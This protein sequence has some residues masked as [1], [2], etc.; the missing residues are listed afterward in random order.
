MKERE[1]EYKTESKRLIQFLTKL[2]L[3]FK[4]NKNLSELEINI[5]NPHFKIND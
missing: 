3:H 1:I 5:T 2:G 4:E